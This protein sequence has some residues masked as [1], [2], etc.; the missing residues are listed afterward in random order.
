MP[1]FPGSHPH[2]EPYR[3]TRTLCVPP[4]SVQMGGFCCWAMGRDTPPPIRLSDE[5]CQVGTDLDEALR[6]ETGEPDRELAVRHG[7]LVVA[8]VPN[9]V[10]PSRHSQVLATEQVL[11]QFALVIW[12]AGDVSLGGTLCR[13]GFLP[14]GTGGLDRADLTLGFGRGCHLLGSEV[15][16]DVIPDVGGDGDDLF[17]ARLGAVHHHDETLGAQGA[18]WRQL[19]Y[20]HCRVGRWGGR[21]VDLNC[22]GGWSP[23]ALDGFGAFHLNQFLVR[24]GH[25]SRGGIVLGVGSERDRESEIL[26]GRHGGDSYHP[27]LVARWAMGWSRLPAGGCCPRVAY[28]APC[29][30]VCRVALPGS[31]PLGDGVWGGWWV[32]ST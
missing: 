1:D 27:L 10:V 6:F 29:Q 26:G 13:F 32:G 4:D 21:L 11:Y 30:P 19:S 24:D 8:S 3:D 12:H 28:R 17:V 25:Y 2:G 7:T 23:L 20:C 15:A 22:G 5:A 18:G 16:G 14:R 31:L 9:E